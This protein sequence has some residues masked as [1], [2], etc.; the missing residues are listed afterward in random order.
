[1]SNNPIECVVD[2]ENDQSKILHFINQHDEDGRVYLLEF[3]SRLSDKFGRIGTG[4][5]FDYAGNR[6][7]G[8]FIRVI[9]HSDRYKR[10]R[11]FMNFGSGIT[12]SFSS[13]IKKKRSKGDKQLK[14]DHHYYAKSTKSGY[15]KIFKDTI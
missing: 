7:Y 8:H 1:M 9:V 11:V 6:N 10:L 5:I 4:G 12:E 2:F 13:D 15:Y 3:D 14:G